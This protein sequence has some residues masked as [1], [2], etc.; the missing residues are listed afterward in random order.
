MTLEDKDLIL[1]LDSIELALNK[2]KDM[3][4]DT[5]FNYCIDRR[6][7]ATLLNYNEEL[8]GNTSYLLRK[9]GWRVLKTLT[10]MQKDDDKEAIK[11]HLKKE[12]E[13]EK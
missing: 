11:K 8:E 10:R 2:Y 12:K 13:L 1:L 6:L 9:C 7:Q 4:R 5:L 3:D